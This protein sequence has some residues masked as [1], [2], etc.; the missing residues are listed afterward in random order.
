MKVVFRTISEIGRELEISWLSSAMGMS[1]DAV[2]LAL[3][4]DKKRA[5]LQSEQLEKHVQAQLE[6]QKNSGSKER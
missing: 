1:K 3:E 5:A 4:N 6:K 2:R